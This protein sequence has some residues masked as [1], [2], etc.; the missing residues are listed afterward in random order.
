MSI[1]N[2]LKELREAAGYNKREV[3][4]KLDMP[5][6]T[7]NNYETGA[8]EAGSETLKKIANLYGVSIDY[9]FENDTQSSA[10]YLDRETAEMAQEI[11]ENPELRI[12]FDASRKV[13]KEDLQLVVDMVKRLKKEDDYID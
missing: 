11:Y 13:S 1:G 4:E 9:I 7:Y 2:K 6:T 5:Y 3:A 10:Y 8:R 12:L